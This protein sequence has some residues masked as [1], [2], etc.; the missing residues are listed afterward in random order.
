VCGASVADS[1]SRGHHLRFPIFVV[2]HY[3]VKLHRA[4]SHAKLNRAKSS[5]AETDLDVI[6]IPSTV[7]VRRSQADPSSLP[8]R[9]R[10]GQD[11]KQRCYP[12]EFCCVKNFH[13]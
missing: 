10:N 3:P 4:A 5:V 13:F 9:R 6:V 11:Q 2:H 1:F 12:S 8:V 7:H